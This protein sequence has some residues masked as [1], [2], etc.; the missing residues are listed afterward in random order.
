[1]A[2]T[3]NIVS[4]GSGDNW[5]NSQLLTAMEQAFQACGMHGGT[6][7]YGVP[8]ACLAPGLSSTSDNPSDSSLATSIGSQAWKTTSP[9]LTGRTPD[10]RNYDVTAKTGNTAWIIKEYWQ[11]TAASNANDTLTVPANSA[12]TTGKE[13]V[14]CPGQSDQAYNL[15]L[16]TL[17]QSYCCLLYTS[18][19]PR[20]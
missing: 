1:M 13:V 2:V 18:P 5:T 16:L 7:R 10:V 11:P 19:S 3:T 17:G 15:D 4:V 6:A 20:D 12:L 9:A 8:T 14:W